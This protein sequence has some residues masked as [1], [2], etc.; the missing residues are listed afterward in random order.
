MRIRI[1]EL[2]GSVRTVNIK[3]GTTIKAW[4]SEFSVPLDGKHI[5]LTNARIIDKKIT[6]D[7]VMENGDLVFICSPAFC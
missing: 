2:P 3:R 4:A 7:R 5:F 6:P 1:A